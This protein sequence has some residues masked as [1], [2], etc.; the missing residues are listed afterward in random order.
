[1]KKFASLIAVSALFVFSSQAQ[2]S[3]S[4]ECSRYVD[5]SPTGGH[6]KVVA[7]SKSEAEQKAMQKYK[8]LKLRTDYVKCH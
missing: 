4:Y 8:E 5:G 7:D 6:V 2:A 3:Y 1:M